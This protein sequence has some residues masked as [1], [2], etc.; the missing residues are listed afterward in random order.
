MKSWLFFDFHA[1]NMHHKVVAD[2]VKHCPQIIQFQPKPVQHRHFPH[3]PERIPDHAPDE[4]KKQII[5]DK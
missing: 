4:F 3:E 5:P 1:Q 2:F